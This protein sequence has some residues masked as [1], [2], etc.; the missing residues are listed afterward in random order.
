MESPVSRDDSRRPTRPVA[1]LCG[2][3]SQDEAVIDSLRL[4]HG[5]R[6]KEQFDPGPSRGESD[7]ARIISSRNGGHL[8]RF[9]QDFR[10]TEDTSPPFVV[11]FRR[12]AAGHSHRM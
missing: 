2:E 4:S 1:T 9:T 7:I 6:V 3:A 10:Q 12:G 5:L 8:Y 11:Q